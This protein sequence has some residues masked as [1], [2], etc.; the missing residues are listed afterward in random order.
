MQRQTVVL[1]GSV[2]TDANLCVCIGLGDETDQTVHAALRLL[3][4]PASV[5]AFLLL[6]SSMKVFFFGFSFSPSCLLG[7]GIS[8]GEARRPVFLLD[9]MA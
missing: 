1:P 6:S 4:S 9:V 8:L 3:L 5:L 2:P 7:L